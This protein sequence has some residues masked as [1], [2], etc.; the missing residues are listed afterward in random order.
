[1]LHEVVKSAHHLRISTCASQTC[2]TLLA[3][4]CIGNILTEISK[5]CILACILEFQRIMDD[6]VSFWNK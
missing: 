4:H 5:S 3:T 6:L 2:D 1:M